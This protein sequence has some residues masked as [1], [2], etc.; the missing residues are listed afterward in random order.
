MI[1]LIK[2]AKKNTRLK[3]GRSRSRYYLI[4]CLFCGN[5][6]VS[7]D[8]GVLAGEVSKDLSLIITQSKELEIMK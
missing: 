2:L 4:N 3:Q 7:V 6:D 1:C 5:F 8:A